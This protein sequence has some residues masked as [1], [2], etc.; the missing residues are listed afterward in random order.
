MPVDVTVCILSL[1]DRHDLLLEALG[2]VRAQSVA[3]S[4]VLIGIDNYAVGE[5]ENCNR[6]LRAASTKYASILHS[7]DLYKPLHI[8]ELLKNIGDADI[9]AAGFDLEGRPEDSIERHHC[10]WDDLRYTNWTWPSALLFDRQRVLDAGGFIEG[11][12]EPFQFT[13]YISFNRWLDF[14]LTWACSHEKT[15]IYKFG[16]WNAGRSWGG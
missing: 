2:S 16:S 3:V 8:E 11:K 9:V 1:P 5:A 10:N 12:P 7:D 6:L 15:C 4:C 13:D 14:G